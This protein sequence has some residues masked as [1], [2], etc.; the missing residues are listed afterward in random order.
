MKYKTKQGLERHIKHK[1]T[2]VQEIKSLDMK[3]LKSVFR[4]SC[5]KLREDECLPDHNRKVYGNVEKVLQN[6]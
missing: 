4:K 2:Q 6:S 1:Y 5:E 3:L